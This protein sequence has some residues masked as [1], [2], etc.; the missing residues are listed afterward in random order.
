[1]DKNGIDKIIADLVE[2]C[3]KQTRMNVRANYG[4]VD[5][6]EQFFAIHCQDYRMDELKAIYDA[7][8]FK[9]FKELIIRTAREANVNED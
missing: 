8:R 7:G 6:P 9:E 4:P 5:R 2:E 3:K 1:M